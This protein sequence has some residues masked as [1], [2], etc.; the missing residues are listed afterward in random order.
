MQKNSTYQSILTHLESIPN[1]YLQYVNTYLKTLLK[2]IRDK[3][4]NRI[5]TMKLAGSWSE[6]SGEEFEDFLKGVQK[7]RSEMFNR[8]IE[9]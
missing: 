4:N 9:L 7:S 5:E 3:E 2:E 6:M 8:E 1:D